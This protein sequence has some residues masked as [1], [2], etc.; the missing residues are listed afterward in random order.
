MVR[1][2]AVLFRPVP[3][4]ACSRSL[5]PRPSSALL[6]PVLAAQTIANVVKSSLGPVGLDKV[7]RCLLVALGGITLEADTTLTPQMMVDDIGVRP[8]CARR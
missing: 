7:C 2:S 1:R 4:A 6:L 5:T 8:P 3:D